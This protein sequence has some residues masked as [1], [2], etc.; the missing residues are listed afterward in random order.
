MQSLLVQYDNERLQESKK[1]FEKFK[2][3][4]A[5]RAA[6]L[7]QNTQL[8]SFTIAFYGET[9]AG[10]STIIE[11]LRIHFQ[12]PRKLAE[13]EW[14]AQR[15]AHLQERENAIQD[16]IAKAQNELAS[17]Q[18]ELES[19]EKQHELECAS[20]FGRLKSLLRLS[21]TKRRILRDKPK[22]IKAQHTLEKFLH[23]DPIAKNRKF[24]LPELVCV[25]DG[26]NIS[27]NTDFT[28]EVIPY[29]FTINNT[30]VQLLDVPGIEGKEE[31]LKSEIKKAT[32]QAHCVLIL[33][34]DKIED[35]TLEMIKQ[36]LNDQTEVYLVFES[37]TSPHALKPI[38][39]NAQM[40]AMTQKVQNAL[41]Q[42]YK[43]AKS[44]YALPALLSQASC[45]IHSHDLSAATQGKDNLLT[46][47]MQ[48]LFLSQYKD[49][50]GDSKP[51][52][53]RRLSDDSGFSDLAAFLASIVMDSRAS[54]Q[55][56]CDNAYALL[57]DFA[58]V[59][60][61][62]ASNYEECCNASTHSALAQYNLPL[63]AQDINR[64]SHM[65]TSGL[66][67]PITQNKSK[68]TAK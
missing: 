35:G 66:L 49:N 53:K 30:S 3:D 13:Q 16:F 58:K 4:F 52:Q 63:Q 59:V 12:E 47:E 38:E 68:Y 48:D 31:K 44:I 56:A 37:A 14:F 45:L 29:R 17:L 51:C 2:D 1:L 41:S 8:D 64:L 43:G 19:L 15:W 26:A 60:D 54:T 33:V 67:A 46:Q 34:R 61:T 39:T 20:F 27:A 32:K 65:I 6:E 57:R 40:Q 24:I 36:G 11:A 10:K 50:C 62:I 55:Q 42:S 25:C 5:T 7:E 9:N 22:T 28:K 21:K 23:N 18:N